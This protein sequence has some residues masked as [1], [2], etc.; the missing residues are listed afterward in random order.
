MEATVFDDSEALDFEVET[1][2]FDLFVVVGFLGVITTFLAEE[3]LA[4]GFLAELLETVVLLAGA[5]FA[6]AVVFA[7][8]LEFPTGRREA[9]APLGS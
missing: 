7:L 8:M 1:T 2:G 4:A 6:F 5:L 9:T 3:L